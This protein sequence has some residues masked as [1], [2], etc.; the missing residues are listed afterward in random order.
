[1][2][3]DEHGEREMRGHLRVKTKQDVKKKI[4]ADVNKTEMLKMNV[5]LNRPPFSN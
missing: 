4:L 1:M 5:S 2:L 3:L